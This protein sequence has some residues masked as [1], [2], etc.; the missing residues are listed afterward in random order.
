MQLVVAILASLYA[1]A[2]NWVMHD[3]ITMREMAVVMSGSVAAACGSSGILSSIMTSIVLIAPKCVLLLTILCSLLEISGAPK[4][5]LLCDY[6]FM[7][8]R[9]SGCLKVCTVSDRLYMCVC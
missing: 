8:A 6:L 5:A 7:C 9:D 4:Y 3:G 1:G 2:V